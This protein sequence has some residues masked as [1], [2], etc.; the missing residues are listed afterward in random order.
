MFTKLCSVVTTMIARQSWSCHTNSAIAKAGIEQHAQ[1]IYSLTHR[2]WNGMNTLFVCIPL[3]LRD[4]CGILSAG[5][6]TPGWAYDW[7]SCL[8]KTRAS[9]S[10]PDTSHIIKRS[11]FRSLCFASGFVG[12]T[13]RFSLDD[14][15][16]GL[17]VSLFANIGY[18]GWLGRSGVTSIPL[19]PSLIIL[20][21][22]LGLTQN[23]GKAQ[24]VTS[25]HDIVNAFTASASGSGL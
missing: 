19:A 12:K 20:C 10:L 9:E 24:N 2:R 6:A 16:T 3:P 7:T 8:R 5:A 13:S 18:H 23:G 15:R 17:C 4:V 11:A 14:T 21:S 22:T 25:D 1:K